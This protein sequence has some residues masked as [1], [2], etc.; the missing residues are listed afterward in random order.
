MAFPSCSY[1]RITAT[2]QPG[3]Q[4]RV[5]WN[6]LQKIYPLSRQVVPTSKLL[7]FENTCAC[8][9]KSNTMTSRHEIMSQI[10]TVFY[11]RGFHNYHIHIAV[12]FLVKHVGRTLIAKIIKELQLKYMNNRESSTWRTWTAL[13]FCEPARY[14]CFNDAILLTTLWLQSLDHQLICHRIYR[15]IHPYPIC[16]QNCLMLAWS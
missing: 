1:S 11:S 14:P 7:K 9:H 12:I 2:T 5:Y 4:I 15:Q 13:F 16:I 10:K 3:S 6:H 8:Y